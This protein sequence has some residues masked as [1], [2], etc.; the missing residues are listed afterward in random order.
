[1]SCE[2]QCCTG[3]ATAQRPCLHV[4]PELHRLCEW[5]PARALPATVTVHA[6]FTPGA[7]RAAAYMQAAEHACM[8]FRR[9]AR[10][11]F[12]HSVTADVQTSTWGRKSSRRAAPSSASRKRC[13]AFLHSIPGFRQLQQGASS[14]LL[15]RQSS[16]VFRG[17]RPADGS[18]ALSNALYSAHLKRAVNVSCFRDMKRA[19]KHWQAL[20]PSVSAGGL[21]GKVWLHAFAQCAGLY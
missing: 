6:T 18:V 15:C 17:S 11:Y 14:S 13:L 19:S 2:P 10:S 1:M 4:L 8:C 16:S 21:T 3:R 9:S 20:Q 7:G 5:Q 12:N